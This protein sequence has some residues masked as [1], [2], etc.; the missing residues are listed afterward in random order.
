[1]RPFALFLHLSLRMVDRTA[2]YFLGF[3]PSFEEQIPSNAGFVES[4]KLL[5]VFFYR[6]SELR[7]CSRCEAAGDILRQLRIRD[8]HPAVSAIARK[9]IGR[10]TFAAQRLRSLYRV[11]R[12]V[13]HE[14]GPR[15]HKQN[16]RTVTRRD[17]LFSI[18]TKIEQQ[19]YRCSRYR[20]VRLSS[21]HSPPPPPPPRPSFSFTPFFP[22]FPFLRS[23][24]S[25]SLQ[26]VLQ[27]VLAKCIY[28]DLL[29]C[30]VGTMHNL[31]R[32]GFAM[33]RYFIFQ[34]RIL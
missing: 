31:L 33:P 9:Q 25:R 7:G 28:E 12:G 13:K 11:Q 15:R 21:L 8:F 20:A 18:M 34:R 24:F 2:I 26:P 27:A 16:S 4:R 23:F 6:S 1:M 5:R 10:T 19:K 30:L 29:L 14:A 32:V 3:D 17:G 22:P